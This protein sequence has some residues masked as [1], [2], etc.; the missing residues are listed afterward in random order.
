M[1]PETKL[2]QQLQSF[3]RW[4]GLTHLVQAIALAVILNTETTIPVITRFFGQ[5]PDGV[6]PVTE[7]LFEFPIALIGPIFLFISA[8]AHLFISSPIPFRSMPALVS[9]SHSCSSI[10]LQST[11]GCNTKRLASGRTTHTARSLTSY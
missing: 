1:K 9:Y 3:N 7:T 11:C 5:T 4:A 10:V 2:G 6:A 8:I